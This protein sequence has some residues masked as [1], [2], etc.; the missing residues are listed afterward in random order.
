MYIIY[1]RHQG[2]GRNRAG[3]YGRWRA[4]SAHV[5]PARVNVCGV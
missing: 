4:A 5:P 3:I 2:P 1:T